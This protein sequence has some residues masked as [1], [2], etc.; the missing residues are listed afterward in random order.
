MYLN[1]CD[2]VNKNL[3]KF[4]LLRRK[5]RL[6]AVTPATAGRHFGVQARALA[7]EV[8]L[9]FGSDLPILFLMP[10]E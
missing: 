1:L 5:P 2:Q 3:V 9:S 7:R 4:A 8:P 10:P 6:P